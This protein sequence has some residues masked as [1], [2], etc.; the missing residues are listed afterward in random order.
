MWKKNLP[1]LYKTAPPNSDCH[2]H[3]TIKVVVLYKDMENKI[4]SGI[5]YC[6][7]DGDDYYWVI[8]DYK[9]KYKEV[10]YWLDHE[11]PVKLQ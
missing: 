5:G 4:K 11:L 10:L 8:D 6:D 9:A 1:P 3:T 7:W 2:D